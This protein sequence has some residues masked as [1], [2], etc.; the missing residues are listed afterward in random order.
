MT[1]ISNTI[2]ELS[3]KFLEAKNG[4]ISKSPFAETFRKAANKNLKPVVKKNQKHFIY[5][6]SPG[7]PPNWASVPWLG[8]FDPNETTSP[9][10]RY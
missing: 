10:R 2:K 3:S 1:M 7:R 4:P 5:K 9:Q 6:S 8:I